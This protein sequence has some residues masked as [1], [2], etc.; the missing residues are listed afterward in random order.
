M[1]FAGRIT[2]FLR[3]IINGGYAYV[4]IIENILKEGALKVLTALHAMMGYSEFA[5]LIEPSESYQIEPFCSQARKGNLD[6]FVTLHQLLV[7][8]NDDS[9]D[10]FNFSDL[11]QYTGEP[12]KDGLGPDELPGTILFHAFITGQTKLIKKFYSFLGRENFLVLLGRVDK[13]NQCIE[14]YYTL[15]YSNLKTISCLAELIGKEALSNLVNIPY[16]DLS[17]GKSETSLQKLRSSTMEKYVELMLV[18]EDA[19]DPI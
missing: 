5:A 17:T 10:N 7:H 3:E 13:A 6:F 1:C 14:I 2:E 9:A 11:F 15:Y 12:I 8:P 18:L 4:S 16:Q 19:F